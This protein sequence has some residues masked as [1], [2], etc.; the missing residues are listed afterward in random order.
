MRPAMVGRPTIK[1]RGMKPTMKRFIVLSPYQENE[2]LAAYTLSRR[3]DDRG[4][5]LGQGLVP[6]AAL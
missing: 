2:V 1:L 3:F 5:G 4:P 6:V